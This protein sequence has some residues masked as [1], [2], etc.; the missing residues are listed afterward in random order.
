MHSRKSM[1]SANAVGKSER[2]VQSRTCFRLPRFM[3]PYP[4]N[5]R[6][7]PRGQAVGC[8]PK[9][10]DATRILAPGHYPPDEYDSWIDP[11]VVVFR[12]VPVWVVAGHHRSTPDESPLYRRQDLGLP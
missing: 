9:L 12:R 11:T 1:R 10:A 8:M 5:V 4:Q 3:A 6:Y 2:D 7:Q